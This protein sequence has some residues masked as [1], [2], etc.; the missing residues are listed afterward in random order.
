LPA[1]V[2]APGSV[3]GS[4][5]AAL[6]NIYRIGIGDVLDVRLSKVTPNRSTL[7]TVT[8]DGLIDFPLAGGTIS[9]ARL[10]H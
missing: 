9:V 8:E 3:A 2:I 6:A 10:D 1:S 4:N 5:E 7:F